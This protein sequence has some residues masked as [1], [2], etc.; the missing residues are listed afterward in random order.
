MDIT[1]QECS[2]TD[3][4]HIK[5]GRWFVCLFP[6]GICHIEKPEKS[7][8]WDP[9]IAGILSH[10]HKMNQIWIAGRKSCY[11]SAHIILDDS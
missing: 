1:N 8:G 2:V 10:I 9:N 4:A 3:E 7:Q 5:I 11:T 6:L